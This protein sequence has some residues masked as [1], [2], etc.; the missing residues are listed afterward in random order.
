MLAG[1]L[2]EMPAA[3]PDRGATAGSAPPPRPL[4]HAR[5][6]NLQRRRHLPDGLPLV[7]PFH[8]ALPQVLRDQFGNCP[9]LRRCPDHLNQIAVANGIPFRFNV[10]SFCSIV[11]QSAGRSKSIP[12]I[13]NGTDRMQR[14]VRS[15]SWAEL[16]SDVSSLLQR[17]DSL[18]YGLTVAGPMLWILGG[19]SSAVALQFAE[20]TAS[21]QSAL[22]RRQTK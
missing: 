20:H 9:S 16:T 12:A 17:C 18:A 22:T 4:H 15:S 6:R 21:R 8:C 7:K 1:D 2:P 11:C 14:P 19:L 5:R 3:G 10:M 13:V